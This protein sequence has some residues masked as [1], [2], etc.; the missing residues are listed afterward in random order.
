MPK[1]FVAGPVSQSLNKKDNVQ[2]S[3]YNKHITEE[4][5]GSRQVEEKKKTFGDLAKLTEATK[6][7]ADLGADVSA[8]EKLPIVQ[9]N[10]KKNA[11][12]DSLVIGETLKDSVSA[13][14]GG[15]KSP[16]K[17]RGI[18]TVLHIGGCS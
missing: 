15:Q 11:L 8:L 2:H 3:K 6:D 4:E 7:L 18:V 12:K 14:K 10:L 16:L 17:N 9:E 5:F 13:E 1:S